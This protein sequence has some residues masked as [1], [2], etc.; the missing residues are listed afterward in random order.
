MKEYEEKM[1]QKRRVEPRF[2]LTLMLLTG[3]L[4][5]A[6][7][8]LESHYL[9]Q[10]DR[11]IAR[12]YEQREQIANQNAALE[13]KIAFTKTDEYIERTARAELGLLKPGEVRFVAGT[14][15]A[16]ADGQ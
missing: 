14:T 2:W 15:A 16:V 1:L 9:A 3:I 4:F 5:G 8:G 10:Q 6:A 13:R 7:Y 11:D 12:L